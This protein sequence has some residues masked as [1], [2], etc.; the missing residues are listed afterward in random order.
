MS[1]NLKN[2]ILKAVAASKEITNGTSK[3]S[4]ESKVELKDPQILQY[5]LEKSLQSPQRLAENVNKSKNE[6]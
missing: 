3:S 6:N 2:D 5:S 4:S 1:D